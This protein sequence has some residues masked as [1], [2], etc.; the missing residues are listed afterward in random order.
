MLLQFSFAQRYNFKVL[1]ED[2]GLPQEFVYHISQDKQGY[3]YFSTGDGFAIYNSRKMLVYKIANGL[4]EN[5]CTTHY[6]A[7]NGDCWI[8]HLQNGITLIHNKHAKALQFSELND[9]KITSII[10]D[11]NGNILIGTLGKG[12][13][14]IDKTY[15]LTQLRN[16][17]SDNISSLCFIQEKLAIGSSD[18]ISFYEYLPQLKYLYDV[19]VLEDIKIT[20]IAKGTENE[21]WLGTFGK[22]IVKLTQHHGKYDFDFEIE[23]G[24]NRDDVNDLFLDGRSIWAGTFGNGI[25]K[26]EFNDMSYKTY[27]IKK[28]DSKSGL[29]NQYINSIFKDEEGNVWSGTSDGGIFQLID[30]KFL[31]YNIENG[32]AHDDIQS[33]ASNNDQLLFIGTHTGLD[34]YDLNKKQIIKTNDVINDEVTALLYDSMGTL[35]IGTANNGLYLKQNKLNTTISANKKFGFSKKHIT[36][37]KSYK[38]FIYVG[39]NEGLVVIDLKN[40]KSKSIS[41]SEGLSNNQINSIAIDKHSNIWFACHGSGPFFYKNGEFTVFK[42]LKGLKSYNLN[43]VNVDDKGNVWFGSEG[44]GVFKFDGKDFTNYTVNDGLISNYAYSIIPAKENIWICSKNGV[45]KF[46]FSKRKFSTYSRDEGFLSQECDFNSY[47]LSN[48]NKVWIGTEQGLMCIDN[49]IHEKEYYPKTHIES[50]QINDSI[51]SPETLKLTYNKYEVKFFVNVINNKGSKKIKFRYKL[52][53]LDRNWSI[54]DAETEFIAYPKLEDGNYIFKVQA[55]N[56]DGDWNPAITELKLNIAKPFWKT[57]WFAI[58]MVAL[59]FASVQLYS[60]YKTKALVQRQRELEKIVDEKTLEIRTQNEQLELS[61]QEITDSITYAKR[62]Q[63]AILPNE[64]ETKLSEQIFVYYK[65]RDIVSGDFYWYYPYTKDEFL[66]AAADCTGHGV[67]GAFLTMMGSTLLN[68]IIKDFDITKPAE[69][70]QKLDSNVRESLHQNNSDATKD[71][72][73]IAICKINTY[74]KNIEFAGAGR[75]LY[76]VR[77]NELL[78]FKPSFHSIGYFHEGSKKE[79]EN[80]SLKTEKGDMLYLFSDGYAD[81]FGGELKQKFMTKRLKE[82][83]KNISAL[84]VENQKLMIDEA[85]QSWKGQNKQIDDILVIGIKMS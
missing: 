38:N 48:E 72:M 39:T 78:E 83:L 5:F 2:I 10:E 20:S 66:I 68:K 80:H 61:N 84:P 13:F 81:Q 26:I 4:A 71:G 33:I 63:E 24:E 22:G 41:T 34:I 47:C 82:L 49:S 19:E 56:E 40:N 30:E 12:L 15:H 59:L 16:L 46:D 37:V 11:K 18:G 79:F 42:D 43:C 73:D 51:Y 60:N 28:F 52:E 6:L 76:L 62:I 44:D 8:G 64:K 54:S 55:C 17:N 77:N 69:I 57:T 32:L 29:Q 67:P 35:W 27:G 25:C 3:L 23:V 21:L 9:A 53:G 70:L 31:L 74:T 1:N 50:I 75:P 58:L 7:S 45:S 85:Y 65:P 14:K 36:C